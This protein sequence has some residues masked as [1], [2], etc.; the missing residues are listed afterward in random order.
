[1]LI[2]NKAKIFS[3]SR[4]LLII[5][6]L[7]V[8]FLLSGCTNKQI[9]EIYNN[10]ILLNGAP[11]SVDIVTRA[12]DMAQGLSNRDKM[13]ENCG[14]LFIM[15]DSVIHHF[16]MKDMRFPLDFVYIN[17]GKIV[18]IFKNV[19]IY[20]NNEFTKINSVENSNMILE[21]NAGF[22]DKNNIKVED[23][24]IFVNN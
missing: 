16:W 6:S 20:T 8:I 12:S 21:L 13:C 5:F 11:V 17:N 24:L 22:L 18:E 14:M 9:K 4:K 23:E 2:K 1:M 7:F 15:P 3:G 10:K 19:S